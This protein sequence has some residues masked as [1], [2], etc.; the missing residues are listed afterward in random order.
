MDENE[1]ILRYIQELAVRIQS[2]RARVNKLKEDGFL[3]TVSGDIVTLADAVPNIPLVQ[4]LA[5]IEP[6]QSGSGDPSPTN[7]RPIS[8]WTGVK[9]MRT[10][11]NVW[12][13]EWELGTFDTTTGEN[14]TNLN[15]IRAKNLIPI[16]PEKEY[17]FKSPLSGT[18][19]FWVIFYD[20]DKNIITDY[21]PTG[22]IGKSG[23][24]YRYNN[25]VCTT[26]QTAYYCRF[27]M[28]ASYGTTYNHDI[29]INY[30]STDTSYHPY[31]GQTY[32]ITFPSEAGTVYGGTLNVTS[33]LL[34]VTH[35][36][37]T[38]NGTESFNNNG[39]LSYGG[40]Q[41]MYTPTPT[42]ANGYPNPQSDLISN[43]FNNKSLV[44]TDPYYINGRTTNGNIYFNMPSGVTT[45]QEARDWFAT[46][47]TQ[48][49]YKLATPITYQLTPTEVRTL[50]GDNNIWADTGSVEVTYKAQ[51][52]R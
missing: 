2:L 16:L 19:G 5:S 14:I 47:S 9:V 26:P 22:Y 20:A 37:Y 42:K 31:Q 52:T 40:L 25:M 36:L 18:D 15:Q 12:D 6:V 13:E 24:S 28:V 4:L 8:G 43:I 39:T 34:T 50:L 11:I 33:G 1:K 49:W 48:I 30:P 32:D 35:T 21:S 23:N 41:I 38:I 46:N 44:I 10:G 45:V 7:V 17:Y 29:S 3:K 27:Y 51:Y